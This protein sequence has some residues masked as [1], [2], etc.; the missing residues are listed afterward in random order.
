MSMLAS[1]G[2]E[3]ENDVTVS[4]SPPSMPMAVKVTGLLPGQRPPVALSAQSSAAEAQARVSGEREAVAEAVA[5][6]RTRPAAS[7]P[8]GLFDHRY[9][10]GTFAYLSRAH[11][12]PHKIEARGA[13]LTYLFYPWTGEGYDTS[14]GKGVKCVDSGANL[15][16]SSKGEDPMPMAQAIAAMAKVKG[17]DRVCVEGEGQFVVHLRRQLKEMGIEV[18]SP[19]GLAEQPA[20]TDAQS[21]TQGRPAG[22]PGAKM[23]TSM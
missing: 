17:W 11:C 20:A 5:S 21:A 13:L 10:D 3:D 9:G 14:L 1:V 6:E 2:A 22:A 18:I 8:D 4:P 23:R 12:Q 7:S 15:Q 16:F 19:L